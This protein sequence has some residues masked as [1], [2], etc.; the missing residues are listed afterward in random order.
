V[1]G[2]WLAKEENGSNG[3]NNSE[4]V[5]VTSAKGDPN[6]GSGSSNLKSGN[7]NPE[8]GICH[9]ELGNH[10]PNSGNN[11]PGK[12]NDQQEEELVSMDVNMVFTISTEFCAPSEDVVELALGAERVVFDKLENPGMHM[13]PL[14]IRGHLDGILVGICSLMEVQA[15]TSCGCHYSR[16]SAMSKVILNVQIL[17]LAVLQV[18]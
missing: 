5:E 2:K 6:P 9:P 3:N 12:G 15:S 14:F 7:C 4:E 18:I 1:V 10:N 17:G 8:T 16:S 13:R 11:N